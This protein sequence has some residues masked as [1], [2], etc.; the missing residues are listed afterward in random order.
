MKEREFI[1]L[2]YQTAKANW[3]SDIKPSDMKSFEQYSEFFVGSFLLA[4]QTGKNNAT[5]WDAIKN[6]FKS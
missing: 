1:K 6:L 2:M 3:K 5:I 4:Y